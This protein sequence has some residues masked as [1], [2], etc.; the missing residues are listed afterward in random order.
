MAKIPDLWATNDKTLKNKKLFKKVL[1]HSLNTCIK[2]VILKS[3][4]SLATPRQFPSIKMGE[5]A[6]EISPQARDLCRT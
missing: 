3:Y 6:D 4:I 5:S 2:M 1:T